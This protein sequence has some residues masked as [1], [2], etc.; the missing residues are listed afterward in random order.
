MTKEESHDSPIKGIRKLMRRSSKLDN[1]NDNDNEV[2]NTSLS[3]NIKNIMT[4]NALKNIFPEMK[5]N[6]SN[7]KA[8]HNLK[9]KFNNKKKMLLDN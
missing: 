7:N 1:D 4:T 8:N 3:Q 2:K 5:Q 9:K 6:V